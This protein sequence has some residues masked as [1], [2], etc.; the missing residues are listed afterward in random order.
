MLETPKHVVGLVP[1]R[2]IQYACEMF[3]FFCLPERRSQTNL[4]LSLSQQFHL[5]KNR[6]GSSYLATCQPLKRSVFFSSVTGYF[7]GFNSI[8]VIP[9]LYSF[10]LFRIFVFSLDCC[11]LLFVLVDFSSMHYF[12]YHVL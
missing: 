11:L 10:S 9:A 4:E 2:S 5:Q 12:W 3:I 7:L 1:T 8:P 6:V